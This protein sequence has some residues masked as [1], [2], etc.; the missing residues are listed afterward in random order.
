MTNPNKK[1]F[2]LL[3]MVITL[4][5]G[6]LVLVAASF[7][8]LSITQLWIKEENLDDFQGHIHGVKTF[9]EKHIKESYYRIND[10]LPQTRWAPPEGVKLDTHDAYLSFLINTPNPLLDMDTTIPMVCYLLQDNKRGLSL[11]WHP[12]EKPNATSEVT[13]HETILSPWVQE[14]KCYY[15]NKNKSDWDILDTARKEKDKFILPDYLQLKFSK[16]GE[17]DQFAYIP[18]YPNHKPEEV[19]L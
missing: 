8:L 9:L 13:V 7:L 11:I 1:A 17:D 16:T 14:I 4:G 15:Y 19:L 12:I 3:E 18:L 5:L 10:Q 2:T 6:A